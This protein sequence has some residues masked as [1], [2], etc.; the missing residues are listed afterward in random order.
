MLKSLSALMVLATLPAFATDHYLVEPMLCQGKIFGDNSRVHPDYSQV[1][2]KFTSFKS[3]RKDGTL[4]DSL[5]VENAY[6]GPDEII[7]P[8]A[9]EFVEA[10]YMGP[11]KK[12]GNRVF[13]ADL[14]GRDDDLELKVISAKDGTETL[15]G[16]Y[17]DPGS[18]AGSYGYKLTC[19][20]TITDKPSRVDNFAR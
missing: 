1:L 12:A 10:W 6:F 14:S 19:E 11:L 16:T 2:M 4:V 17:S 9:A 8:E 5:Q 15:E 13:R 18:V 20:A 7:S 3:T